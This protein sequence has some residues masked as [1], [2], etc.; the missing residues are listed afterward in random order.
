MEL[1]AINEVTGF[2]WL[3]SR[4]KMRLLSSG[5][6]SQRLSESLPTSSSSEEE[7]IVDSPVAVSKAHSPLKVY[8]EVNGKVLCG[9][10]WGRS[11]DITDERQSKLDATVDHIFANYATEHTDCDPDLL[12][13]G[14]RIAVRQ[15][16]CS[17]FRRLSKQ[18]YIM[19]PSFELDHE[20]GQW[21][22]KNLIRIQNTSPHDLRARAADVP[23]N[24][25]W[26]DLFFHNCQLFIMQLLCEQYD[27]DFR[28]LP[29]AVGSVVA[30]PTLFALEVGFITTFRFLLRWQ[31]AMAML[32][33]V[34]WVAA[35]VYL[36]LRY[37]HSYDVRPTS[38]IVIGSIGTMFVWVGAVFNRTLHNDDTDIA[39]SLPVLSLI[40][41]LC[42]ILE[43]LAT[44]MIYRDRSLQVLN[45]VL[46]VLTAAGVAGLQLLIGWPVQDLFGGV[47][48][49]MALCYSVLFGS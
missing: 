43:A 7:D 12:L 28:Q 24:D 30:A 19:S 41:D 26:Y 33:G 27:A 36:T 40:W 9:F 14:N 39:D 29:L 21:R 23:L 22:C 6:G 1:T 3:R 20:G 37:V 18:S 35:E 45:L 46:I 5:A 47:V 49:V 4:C 10:E 13:D 16:L 48:V 11:S 15:S 34:L 25:A 44:N 17:F 2:R 8:L 42:M 38:G 32:I 31:P